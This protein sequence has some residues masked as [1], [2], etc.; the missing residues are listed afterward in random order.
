[1]PGRHDQRREERDPCALLRTE[2]HL[3][4]LQAM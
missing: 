1:M 4:A 2:G 3:A